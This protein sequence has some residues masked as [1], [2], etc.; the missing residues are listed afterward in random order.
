MDEFG[1]GNMTTNLPPNL[2]PVHN[3]WKAEGNNGEVSNE[4][5]SAGGSSGGSAAAVKGGLAWAY[6]TV[7]DSSLINPTS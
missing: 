5:R 1:M 3:P 2:P 6:V 4:P 7:T